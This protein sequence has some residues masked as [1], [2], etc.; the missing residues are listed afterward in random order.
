MHTILQEQAMFRCLECGKKFRTTA[1]AQ[2]AVHNGCSG[3]GGADID[4][5][6][7]PTP[8]RKAKAPVRKQ[9]HDGYYG[10]E[11]DPLRPIV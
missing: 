11:P 4:L 5:D 6:M 3:C 8:V 10:E 9:P 2:R 7:D 1:A